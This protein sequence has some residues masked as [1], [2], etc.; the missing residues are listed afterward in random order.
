MRIS[1]GNVNTVSR[2][3]ST[4]SPTPEKSKSVQ[5]SNSGELAA[6]YEKSSYTDSTNENLSTYSAPRMALAS[7]E[8]PPPVNPVYENWLQ[9]L[10]QSQNQYIESVFRRLDE[11]RNGFNNDEVPE[12]LNQHMEWLQ[13]SLD[14]LATRLEQAEKD[15]LITSDEAAE[16]WL[17]GENLINQLDVE[18][19][20]DVEDLI[21]ANRI[22]TIDARTTYTD[23]DKQLSYTGSNYLQNM[24][25]AIKNESGFISKD[26][27]DQYLV[28]LNKWVTARSD[29]LASALSDAPTG[30]KTT[31]LEN[32]Q[33]KLNTLRQGYSN[34]IYQ[35][36]NNHNYP[37]KPP[38]ADSLFTAG[39]QKF[40][41]MVGN[42]KASLTV[43]LSNG[44]SSS[45]SFYVIDAMGNKK[46][47]NITFDNADLQ[48]EFDKRY[49]ESTFGKGDKALS[50]EKLNSILGSIK[51]S[52][53]KISD[54]DM[55]RLKSKLYGKTESTALDN[56]FTIFLAKLKLAVI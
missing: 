34:L 35:Q 12:L 8:E 39:K 55:E 23:W 52:L 50:L 20:S 49:K 28:E 18:I 6:I 53:L 19:W 24:E 40:E 46:K 13:S 11:D 15:L 21:I 44:Q 22:L 38:S 31:L 9:S 7:S 17:D 42:H 2:T 30:I 27:L 45:S 56:K 3:Y 47:V 1:N 5:S 26:K 54:T 14:D 41:F 36:V 33:A 25:S 29:E 10:P 51:D 4:S 48:R 37:P 32:A 16:L 43:R